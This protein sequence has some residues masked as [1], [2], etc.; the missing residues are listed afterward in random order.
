MLNPT[1]NN[2]TTVSPASIAERS[3]ALDKATAAAAPAPEV[4]EEVK[5]DVTSDNAQVTDNK[6]PIAKVEVK[7]D[8]KVEAVKNPLDAVANKVVPQTDSELRKWAT[9]NAQDNAQLRKDLAAIKKMV[10]EGT[11]KPVDLEALRKDPAQFKKYFDEQAVAQQQLQNNYQIAVKQNQFIQESQKRMTDTVNYPDWKKAAAII[12]HLY[13]SKDPGIL[14]LVPNGDWNA[15][16]A[17]EGLDL[18][19]NYV[20]DKIGQV[21]WTKVPGFE[22][23]KAI[24]EAEF[25]KREAEAEKRGYEKALAEAKNRA[26]GST[27]AGM[28]GARTNKRPIAQDFR[29][30][31]LKELEKYVAKNRQAE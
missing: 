22:D 25:T 30:M 16:D 1:D 2:E 20:K 9:K 12:D 4:K 8:K 17:V 26:N 3:E 13:N 5:A 24:M 19:Y 31:D 28:S 14:N 15:I 21:D 7:D 29:N 10:E 6:E 11:K 18:A 23:T 27:V